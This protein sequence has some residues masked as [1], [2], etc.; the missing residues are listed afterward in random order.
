MRLSQP[1]GA[2]PQPQRLVYTL[3]LI[4]G[5]I[6]LVGVSLDLLALSLSPLQASLEWRMGYMQQVGERCVILLFAGGLLCH[7][8]QPRPRGLKRLAWACCGLG[9]CLSLSSFFYLRDS[10]Q[11]SSLA[12][13]N[14]ATQTQNLEQR[15]QTF[16]PQP[17]SPLN[18]NV[19]AAQKARAIE[20]LGESAQALEARAKIGIQKTAIRTFFSLLL[21]GLGLVAL[22]QIA[23]YAPLSRSPR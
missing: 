22:G 2:L 20:R 18:L 15:I 19:D 5:L 7:G 13:A 11:F 14:L 16:A 4:T 1:S 12:I 21:A 6:C 8:F 3:A 17:N 10:V 23:L 9:L